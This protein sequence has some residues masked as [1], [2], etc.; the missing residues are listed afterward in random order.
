ST[1]SFGNVIVGPLNALARSACVY[2]LLSLMNWQEAWFRRTS[3]ATQLAGGA[4]AAGVGKLPA[5]ASPGALHG[6]GTPPTCAAGAACSPVGRCA[7]SR[8]LVWNRLLLR[9]AA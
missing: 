6:V 7:R 1:A 5:A 3:S 2:S 4:V 8:K 9:V